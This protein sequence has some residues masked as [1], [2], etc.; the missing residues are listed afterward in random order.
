MDIDM[1]VTELEFK[2]QAGEIPPKIFQ[3]ELHV[4]CKSDNKNVLEDIKDTLTS[5]IPSY[6]A[7]Y[8]VEF[9]IAG[10]VTEVGDVQEKP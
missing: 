7:Y 5:L 9:E 2:E 10:G 6:S 1:P 4:V 3:L 8:F